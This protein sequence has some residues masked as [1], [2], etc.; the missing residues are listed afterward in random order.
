MKRITAIMIVL[1]AII[2]FCTAVQGKSLTEHP[3]TDAGD[4]WRMGVQAYSFKNF[5]FCEAIDKAASMGLNWIEAY[6]G[7]KLSKDRPGVKFGHNMPLELREEVK[8]KLA[9]ANVK[10]VSYGV[11]GLPNNEVECRKVFEFAKDMGIENI[12]SEPKENAFDLIERLCKEYK[13]AVAIHNHPKPSRYWNPD[14]VLK[15]CKGRSKWIGAC[16][17]TGHWMRSGIDPL[18]ALKKLEGRVIYFHMKDLNEFGVRKAHDMPWGTGKANMRGIL[19]YLNKIKWRG[20]VSSEYEH[21]WLNS[22][23]EIRQCAIFFN[24]V[25]AELNPSGWRNLLANDLANCKLKQGSWQ[26]NDNVLT[27]VGGG[28]IWTKDKYGDFILDLEFKV[29]KGA[30]SGVLIRC[31]D[32]KKWVH[33]TIEVQIHDTTDGTKH[34]QCGAVYDCLSPKK[35]LPSMADKWNHMTVKAVGPQIYVVLN[36]EQIIDMNVD[37]WTEPNKNPDYVGT[38]NKFN[39]AIKDMPRVGHIGFQDHGDPVW[40]R[41]V[42]IKHLDK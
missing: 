15:I 30:N 33:T 28:N 16:A 36:G 32:L 2:T 41:N 3:A 11:V 42:R 21:N 22:V 24:K 18:E 19:E 4:G 38:Q 31:G 17:D 39:T 7:Q 40:Y 26:L 34:G 37:D 13:I 8:K 20:A 5:T 25:G 35:E 10:L 1:S 14:T 23:P 9:A 6:S 27:R 29:A 12:G